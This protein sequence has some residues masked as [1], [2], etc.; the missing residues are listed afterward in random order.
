[1]NM[2]QHISFKMCLFWICF[3]CNVITTISHI[4]GVRW[5]MK[6]IATVNYSP[7]FNL[8]TPSL[9]TSFKLIFYVNMQIP[10][11]AFRYY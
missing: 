1:M 2:I 11:L 10:N 8:I 9:T 6:F 5:R 3:K 4:L 7:V